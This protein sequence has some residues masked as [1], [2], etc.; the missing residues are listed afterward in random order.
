MK[1]TTLT[2][3]FVL[4]TL[5]SCIDD[6]L[7]C[8][9]TNDVPEEITK[10]YSLTLAVTLDKMGG[11]TRS[12]NTT[13]LE[14]FESY[15][16]LEKF[17]VL[18]FDSEDKFLFESKS[19]WV[20]QIGATSD[21]FSQWLVSVPVFS[22]GNDKDYNWDWEEIRDVLTK[23]EDTNGVSFKIAI[24][25]NRPDR[26]ALPELE[27]NRYAS[28][29]KHFDNSGP[30]WKQKDTRW[31]TEPKEVFDLHHCQWDPIYENKGRP[32]ETQSNQTVQWKGQNFYAF[33]M[34]EQTADDGKTER[35]MSATSSWVDFG[36]DLSDDEKYHHGT[37]T[38]RRFAKR[39]D[40]SYPIPMYGIQN[41]GRITNWIEGTPFNLS[42][43]TQNSDDQFGDYV[44]KKIALLRSVVRVDLKLRKTIFGS[45]NPAVPSFIALAYCNIYARC[46]PMDVWTPTEELWGGEHDGVDK[47]CEYYL[48]RKHGLMAKNSVT[49][50]I[51]AADA[52][53]ESYDAGSFKAY[54]ERLSWYYGAW[55]EKGWDFGTLGAQRVKELYG[56]ETDRKNDQKFPH[57]FNSAIQRNQYAMCDKVRYTGFPDDND[58][59]HY[60]VYTGERNMNDPNRI[61]N[62]DA[63]GGFAGTICHWKFNVGSLAYS[64]PLTDY[65][66]GNPSREI[67]NSSNS[68]DKSSEYKPSSSSEP[69]HPAGLTKYADNLQTNSTYTDDKYPWPLLRNHVYVLT[70]DPNSSGTAS[71]SSTRSGKYEEEAFTVRTEEFY[72]RSLKSN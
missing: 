54:R 30:N 35:T 58:Y 23:E 18:F 21:G 66:A 19:R 42:N 7:E 61:Y 10:G 70:I 48:I 17:R 31:G 53:G 51:N 62:I 72:S 71:K 43:I 29:T 16:D 1:Y 64:Y 8:M 45:N 50:T 52:Q 46:E 22:Y 5:S 47:S 60:V 28:G 3:L 67:F 36:P 39:A 37:Y 12:A 25:A 59:F 63:T 40:K 57:I 6:D 65:G 49:G 13:E 11:N 27:D 44:Y 38:K 33:V 69:A 55:L 24:L 15:I 14:E 2:A 4:V 32:T 9:D 56:E 41:F 26:E 68:A 34:G 20:K